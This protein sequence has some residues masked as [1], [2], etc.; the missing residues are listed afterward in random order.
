VVV[1]NGGYR[2]RWQRSGGSLRLRRATCQRYSHNSEKDDL[3]N[4]CFCG[5]MNGTY[6]FSNAVEVDGTRFESELLT[7]L[8]LLTALN[9]YGELKLFDVIL[10]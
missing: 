9:P 10:F 1:L 6:S 7:M 4:I 5:W 8:Y 3:Y 2:Q